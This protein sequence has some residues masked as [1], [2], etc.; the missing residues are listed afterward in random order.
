M[1]E[2]IQ[3]QQNQL[4]RQDTG[5]AVL[6]FREEDMERT[7][8]S[9]PVWERRNDAP[10]EITAALD[11][12]ASSGEKVES[13][14]GALSYAAQG[15]NAANGQPE[16]FGFGDLVD[17]VNP[18]QHIPLVNHLY[19]NITG[20]EIKPISRIIG[21][22]IFGGPIGGAAALVNV[23]VESETG[24]D[25]TENML[26]MVTNDREPDF[27]SVPDEPEQR[28]AQAIRNS[29]EKDPAQELPGNMLSFVDLGGGHRRVVERFAD[30]DLERTAGTMIRRY[31]E[32]P[33]S[34]DAADFLPAREP[35]TTLSFT[36]MADLKTGNQNKLISL[37][38]NYEN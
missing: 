15:E 11:T 8:G 18:L 7:A 3:N 33:D 38:L 29:G 30:N 31:T 27:R 12:A 20:D 17:M 16:E 26:A 22:S 13:F 28:L 1:I 9:M 14:H 2:P 6:R 35:I 21:G 24:K 32:G 25:V 4:P 5:R 34:P 10:E 19:R 37:P 36:P 23:A